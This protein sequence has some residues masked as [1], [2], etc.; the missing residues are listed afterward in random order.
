MVAPF[1][2]P[3]HDQND[4]KLEQA[5]ALARQRLP[6]LV[7]EFLLLSRAPAPSAVVAKPKKAKK[8]DP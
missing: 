6:A 3:N 4:P 2:S 1:A 7:A 8:G 5:R